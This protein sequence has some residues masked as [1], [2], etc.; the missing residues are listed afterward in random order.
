MQVRRFI[1]D[2][3]PVAGADVVL[4]GAEARHAVK[5]LRLRPGDRLDLLDGKGVRAEAVVAP[6]GPGVRPEGLACRVVGRL[7]CPEP[8]LCIRL[9][10]AP[11]RS[12]LMG[13]VVRCATELGVRRITPVLCRFGVSRP[14][15]EARTGWLQDASVALKQSGNAFLPE[16][17]SPCLF[18]E[19]LRDA[20][21]AGVFGA[22]PDAHAGPAPPL[23]RAAS[24]GLWI[25]PEGGFC[26]AEVEALSARGFA[27]LT[28]GP[29]IL[30]VETAVAALIGRLWGEAGHA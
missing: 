2:S 18:Q 6:V 10:I 28:V 26:A 8:A 23:P 3:I 21:P 5:V 16:V 1:V 25:G 24:I 11:P 15:S 9:Y 27:P 19:A 20:S 17:D 12:G 30:R 4:P 7:C 13:D 22:V 29:W 14:G